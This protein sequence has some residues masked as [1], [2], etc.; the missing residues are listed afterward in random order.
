MI[1]KILLIIAL[2]FL[3]LFQASFLVHFSLWGWVINLVLILVILLNIFE[4]PEGNMGFYGAFFGGFFLDI[5]SNAIIGFN[6]LILI[7]I[8]FAIKMITNKY[9][10]IPFKKI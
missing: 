4:N 8:A 1:K 10:R 2:Y 3:T 7:I 5:F 9:V 6:I